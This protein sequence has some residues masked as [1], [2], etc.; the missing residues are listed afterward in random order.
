[1]NDFWNT[2]IFLLIFS[3]I[4]TFFLMQKGLHSAFGAT[5]P[6]S[7]LD[8]RKWVVVDPLLAQ[9]PTP[10]MTQAP[11][12]PPGSPGPSGAPG[13]PGSGTTNIVIPPATAEP[14][15]VLGMDPVVAT[16]VGIA[17]ILMI[18]LIAVGLSRSDHVH[19][20]K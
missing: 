19:I 16:I 1:M 3:I 9:A 13:S 20:E 11:S 6:F 15:T 12:G 10:T 2:K 17:V 8:Q 14:T 18:T 4:A 7:Q 5:Q